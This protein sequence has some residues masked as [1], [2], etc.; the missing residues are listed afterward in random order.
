[1]RCTDN[2]YFLFFNIQSYKFIWRYVILK[3]KKDYNKMSKEEL[4]KLRVK[5]RGQDKVILNMLL[6]K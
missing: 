4:K 6:S 3:T 5:A 2:Y 1:M